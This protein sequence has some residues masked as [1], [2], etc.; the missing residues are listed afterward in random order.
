MSD[1]QYP[2]GR[3]QAKKG[4]T[5]RDV[6]KWIDQLEQLPSQINS[7]VTAL[8]DK[9]LDTPY[10]EGGWTIRTLIHHVA[11]SHLNAY[12]RI[13]WALTEDRPTI[14]PYDQDLWA[15]LPD[16][17]LAV[18]ASLQVIDGI[19]RRL[20]KLLKSLDED[21]LSRELVHPESGTLTVKSLIGLY[22]W[23]GRHHLAHITTL[24][25][26]KNWT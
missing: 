16:S 19:H 13:K 23:H 1:S 8:S 24:K 9:Q 6:A 15:N 2:I 7:A 11:D 5:P 4:A 3:Y 10:R 17:T 18:S 25:E 22:A 12:I 21:Q 20:V 14:K 26:H